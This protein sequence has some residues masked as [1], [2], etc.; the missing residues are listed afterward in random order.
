ME[1][2]LEGKDSAKVRIGA[3]DPTG[4]SLATAL[5]VVYRTRLRLN[6]ILIAEEP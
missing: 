2:I 4:S 5:Y 1:T 6:Q 3:K